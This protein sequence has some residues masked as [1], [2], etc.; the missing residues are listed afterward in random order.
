MC[1]GWPNQA[2]YTARTCGGGPDTLWFDPALRR[3][4]EWEHPCARERRK[5]KE[6][7]ARETIIKPHLTSSLPTLG[8]AAIAR[9]IPEGLEVFR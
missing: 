1:L 2:S 4:A 3:D 9:H 6:A 7:V 5:S 8:D